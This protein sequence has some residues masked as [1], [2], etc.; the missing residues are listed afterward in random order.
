MTP[1]EFARVVRM[2]AIKR[3]TKTRDDGVEIAWLS[4]TPAQAQP[5]RE[6]IAD[7]WCELLAD[8]PDT[9]RATRISCRYESDQGGRRSTSRRVQLTLVAEVIPKMESSAP[10]VP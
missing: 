7:G 8:M 9:H 10:R 3:S 6:A 5:A 4:V 1:E 2:S